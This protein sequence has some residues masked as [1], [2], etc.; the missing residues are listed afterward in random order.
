VD[1]HGCVLGSI[2]LCV[3]IERGCA[4]VCVLGC[5]GV[6][7]CACRACMCVREHVCVSE[8]QHVCISEACE[9]VRP[10][11]RACVRACV[12]AIVMRA[13]GAALRQS[14]CTPL[15]AASQK[16]HAEVVTALLAKG[17]DPEA[18]D[19]VSIMA[20]QAPSPSVHLAHSPT[21]RMRMAAINFRV[22]VYLPFCLSRWRFGCKARGLTH[23][24]SRGLI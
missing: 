15:Y 2:G 10:F 22:A 14:G 7:V 6:F 13:M 9:K 23:G 16:C 12:L 24:R 17:A 4:C 1:V 3:H 18:K 21:C 20:M 5:I 8:C 19:N 11:V